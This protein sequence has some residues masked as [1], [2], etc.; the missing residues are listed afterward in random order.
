MGGNHHR[1]QR[2]G[3]ASTIAHANL[4]FGI[5]KDTRDQALFACL[6]QV[7]HQ[8][9]GH[10]DRHRHKLF[11]L[12][13]GIAEHQTLVARPFVGFQLCGLGMQIVLDLT[14]M[15]K[16]QVGIGIADITDDPADDG[17]HLHIHTGGR[18]N[19][20]GNDYPVFSGQ[21]FAG[22]PGM[23]VP[24]QPGVQNGV[25][26]LVANLVRMSFRDRFRGE[27]ILVPVAGFVCV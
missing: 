12:V 2:H 5:W 13:A 22:Y 10:C 7:F 1:F 25:R 11:G 19:F 24:A 23:G 26:D 17:F 3:P 18:G 27:N 20:T 8:Q 21:C 9:V 4:G 15:V 6:G 14:V 16:T